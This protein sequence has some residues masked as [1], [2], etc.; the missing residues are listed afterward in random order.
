MS[1]DWWWVELSGGDVNRDEGF[2]VCS[3]WQ[4]CGRGFKGAVNID[5]QELLCGRDGVF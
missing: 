1:F 2:S 3:D 5:V 4:V